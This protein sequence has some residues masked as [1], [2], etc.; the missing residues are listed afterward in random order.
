MTEKRVNIRYPIVFPTKVVWQ[1]GPG[2]PIVSEGVTENVGIADVLL[3]L[4]HRLPAVGSK[5]DL[6]VMLN[7]DSEITVSVRV[8]RLER[9][10]SHPTAAFKLEPTSK[11]WVKNVWEHARELVAAEKADVEWFDE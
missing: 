9:N 4:R 8:L 5:V 3:H 1:D 7:S 6:T 11:G 10:A 2:D